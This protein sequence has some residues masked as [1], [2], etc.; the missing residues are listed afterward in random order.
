MPA[1]RFP[2]GPTALGWRHCL[3]SF[4]L[5]FIV[6]LASSVSQHKQIGS[7][8]R[9]R[10]FYLMDLA[11]LFKM[12]KAH[13]CLGHRGT[14]VCKEGWTSTWRQGFGGGWPQVWLDIGPHLPTIPVVVPPASRSQS[15]CGPGSQVYSFGAVV[16]KAAPWESIRGET[17]LLFK[18]TDIRTLRGKLLPSSGHPCRAY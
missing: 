6:L 3:S 7:V 12:R 15:W 5:W 18:S 8:V 1:F 9:P 2:Q 17:G 4:Y 14:E 16:E 11:S 13:S 10:E